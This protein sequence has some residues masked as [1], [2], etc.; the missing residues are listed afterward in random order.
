MDSNARRNTWNRLEKG[1]LRLQL[2]EL[3]SLSEKHKLQAN[4]KLLDCLTAVTLYV[5]QTHLTANPPRIHLRRGNITSPYLESYLAQGSQIRRY[6]PNGVPD[7]FHLL[8][9]P[10]GILIGKEIMGT[11]E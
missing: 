9:S 4:N 2:S 7:F 3:N 1:H 5:C 8:F 11:H 6:F 10:P